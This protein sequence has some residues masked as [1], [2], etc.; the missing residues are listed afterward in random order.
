MCDSVKLSGGKKHYQV[1]QLVKKTLWGKNKS[2]V[3][4]K[5]SCVMRG[6][7]LKRHM[8]LHQKR[9]ETKNL[10]KMTL[11][12]I[13]YAFHEANIPIKFPQCSLKL[14]GISFSPF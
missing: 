14:P 11:N 12:V 1:K 9:G 3:C 6:D 13:K 10:D 2:A 4:Q 8:K 7:V 5:C